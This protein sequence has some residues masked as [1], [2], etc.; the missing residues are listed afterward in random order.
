[1]TAPDPETAERIARTLVKRRL[2]AC[3][4]VLPGITSIFRWQGAIEREAEVLVVMKTRADR[5]G[6]L[7]ES[8]PAL[9]PYDVPEFL[10]VPVEAGHAPYLDWVRDSTDPNSDQG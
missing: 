2:I 6:E 3:G 4:N 8:A 7:L 9:H 10:V 1:M 5:V